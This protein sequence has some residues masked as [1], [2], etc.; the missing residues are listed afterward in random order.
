MSRQPIPDSG[1]D[2]RLFFAGTAGSGKTYNA[3]G[4]VERLLAKGAR[5]VIPDPLGVWWGLRLA[6]DGQHSSG[7][8][9]AIFGGP[10]GDLPLTEHAGALIGETVAGMKESCI[11]DLS[12]LGTK[13]AERRFMLAFLTALYKHTTGEPLHV[14]FDEADMWSPQRLLDKEGEAAKLLGMMETVVRRGRV[15]G[16][17]PWLISQRPAVIS[18]DVLSQ[19]DGLIAFKLTSSQDRDAIGDWVEGQADRAQWRDIWASLPTMERG[20]G[21]VWIPQ[22]AILHTVQFPTKETF[23][24]S[25]TPKRGERA[26]RAAQL[27]PLDLS[28]LKERLAS[29][30]AETKANDPA[31]LRAEIAKL[32]REQVVT[33]PMDPRVLAQAEQR[34]RLV[35]WHEGIEAARAVISS[36]ALALDRAIA[37]LKTLG[38]RVHVVSPPVKTNGYKPL[39]APPRAPS[40]PRKSLTLGDVKLQKAERKILTALAQ[41]PHGRT[42]NQVAVLAAYAVN[43]GGFNNA[44]SAMRSAG[45]LIGSGDHLEITKEGLAVLGDYDPLPTGT[46]LLNHWLG[47]LG[48]AERELLRVLADAYPR[49]MSKDEVAQHAGYEAS[50][51]G[52][53]NAISRLR[54]LE[55]VSGRGAL[56]ASDNLFG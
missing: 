31:A 15:R 27:K 44:L 17:I 43:G 41:Y 25:R 24:S 47:Q 29:V 42:K 18:K 38:P 5:V 26:Q 4:R 46:N 20:Q 54:T 36:P 28:R 6:S 45:Y 11:L 51:G 30:E 19:V 37:D 3:M 48:K 34:G 9:V 16:F 12:Q 23:D 40:Y 21:V 1:L 39:P 56:K 14:I 33:P 53:N 52:F 50:G 7:F 13:A 32:K 49:A 2:D 10:H 55:L 35:G 8:D 22:R